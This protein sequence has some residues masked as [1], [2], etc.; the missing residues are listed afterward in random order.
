MKW[1]CVTGSVLAAVVTAIVAPLVVPIPP[2][3]GTKPAEELGDS[4]SQFL[5]IAGVRVHAKIAGDGEHSI[6]LLHGF[7]ANVFSWRNVLPAL[8]RLGRVVAYDRTGFGLT[9]RPLPGAWRG[10]SP[11]GLEAQVDLLIA[12]L[13]KLGIER[14]VLVGHSAGTVVALNAALQHPTRVK[15]LVL[16]APAVMAGGHMPFGLL[17]VLRSPQ[18]RRLGPLLLRV[19]M[20]R[21]ERAMDLAWHDPAA[22]TPELR[23]GYTR[24]FLA[25]NWDVGLYEVT[26]AAR[27]P[28]WDESA[29]RALDIPALL[30]LGDHDRLVRRPHA[31]WLAGLLPKARLVDV[32]ACG[33]I[34]HEER[35][36][37]F[38]G[39]VKG[40]LASLLTQEG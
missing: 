12:L 30:L 31:E 16:A 24:P 36:E 17:P 9:S 15:A 6:V 4:D 39:E 32:A 5:D 3:K 2:L 37:V 38:L 14:A 8:A 25:D 20:P 35:P 27:L 13:D 7:A 29:L 18:L 28:R 10:A 22:I 11:Y 33:H 34:P 23:E 21:L 40:F 19:V 1:R 26:A